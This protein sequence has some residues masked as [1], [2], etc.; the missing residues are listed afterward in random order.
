MLRLLVFNTTFNNILN[1]IVVAA[2][3]FEGGGNMGNKSLLV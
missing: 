3:D 1:Y 2:I